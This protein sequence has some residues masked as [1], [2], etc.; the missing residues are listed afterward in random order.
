V[1]SPRISVNWMAACMALYLVFIAAT[2]FYRPWR[3]LADSV[4]FWDLPWFF[5][6]MCLMAAAYHR[7]MVWKTAPVEV[8]APAPTEPATAPAPSNALPAL[9]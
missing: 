8:A 4:R 6:L 1:E 9:S 2:N 3:I 7:V 5:G